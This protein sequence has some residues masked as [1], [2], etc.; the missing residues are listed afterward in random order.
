MRKLLVC[1]ALCACSSTPPAASPKQCALIEA[2]FA[3]TRDLIIDEGACDR[4]DQIESCPAYMTLEQLYVAAIE[5]GR[6][7]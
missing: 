2:Q 5:A 6:C 1:L 4:F 7:P 3:S